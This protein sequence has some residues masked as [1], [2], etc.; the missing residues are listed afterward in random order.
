MLVHNCIPELLPSPFGQS[1]SS[2]TQGLQQ[3]NFFETLGETRSHLPQYQ[4]TQYYDSYQSMVSSK[5][6]AKST[7]VPIPHS[8]FCSSF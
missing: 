3:L 2:L 4:P 5:C 7:S 8:G 6:E 1:I